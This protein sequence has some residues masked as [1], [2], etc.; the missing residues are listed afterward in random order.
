MVSSKWISVAEVPKVG[1]SRRP[2]LRSDLAP[3]IRGP[4]CQIGT[5]LKSYV[6]NTRLCVWINLAEGNVRFGVVVVNK[7]GEQRRVYRSVQSVGFVPCYC[8]GMSGE[9]ISS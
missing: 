9:V 8:E 7:F 5:V 3:K 1:Y 4:R 2:I 6:G